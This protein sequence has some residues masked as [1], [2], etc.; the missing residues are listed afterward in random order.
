MVHSLYW[1]HNFQ[2]P[3]TITDWSK[4]S[5]G[6]NIFSIVCV[7]VPTIIYLL[8]NLLKKIKGTQIPAVSLFS[9]ETR[10]SYL[11]YLSI[12]YF[13]GNFLFVLLTQ[14]GNLNGLHRYIFD[15]PFFYILFFILL[16]KLRTI[17]VKPLL[18][19]LIPLGAIGYLLLVHGPY[20]HQITFLDMGYFLLIF[21]L[22]FMFAYR[23]I[24]IPV[25]ISWVLFI[26]LGN[27]VWLTYLFNHFLNNSFI[28][29]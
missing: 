27:T 8:K 4:E 14:G 16:E 9:I 12:I 29:A 3:R 18:L 13:I 24:N 22:I 6:M 25:K 2:I 20:Q 23:A 1:D 17:Q 28:I 10:K 19:I 11:F 26:I 7:V 21:N 15:S 5:Y